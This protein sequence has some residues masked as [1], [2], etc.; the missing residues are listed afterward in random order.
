MPPMPLAA[1]LDE[2]KALAAA[3]PPNHRLQSAEVADVLSA[4]VAVAQ[5][6]DGLIAAAKEGG[7]AVHQFYHDAIA[8]QAEADGNPAPVKGQALTDPAP[9]T[10]ATA[11]AQAIDYDQLAAAIV[12]AQGAHNAPTE[13]T[14]AGSGETKDAAVTD[15]PPSSETGIL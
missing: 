15:T 3:L 14:P 11:T 4:L 8:K 10:P 2:L 5:H 7:T 13:V 9:A 12:K 1:T 6:G